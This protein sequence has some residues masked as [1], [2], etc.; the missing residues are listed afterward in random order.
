VPT[1]VRVLLVEDNPGDADLTVEF[2]QESQLDVETAVAVD[3]VE[4]IEYLT[5][6][7][8]YASAPIPDLILLDLNLPRM[9]GL[10]V[11]NEIKQ[12]AELRKI[13]IVVLSSSASDRDIVGSYESGASCYVRKPIELTDYHTAIAAIES[14]WFRIAKLP[15]A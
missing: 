8:R 10:K 7:G 6:S 11:L 2:L 3:G 12:R 4:A 15:G 9:D 14:F 1:K 13:P 5:R